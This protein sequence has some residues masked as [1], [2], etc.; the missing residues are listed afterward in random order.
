MNTCANKKINYSLTDKNQT[1]S[2]TKLSYMGM[3]QIQHS[4]LIRT[5]CYQV[6]STG[7]MSHS[8]HVKDN[9]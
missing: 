7:R 4:S 9:L 8:L 2:T 3:N 1:S 5:G 6:P